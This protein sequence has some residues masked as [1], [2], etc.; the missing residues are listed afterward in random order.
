MQRKQKQHRDLQRRGVREEPL[1]VR[2]AA[3]CSMTVQRPPG[4]LAT[5]QSRKWTWL[6]LLPPPPPP[7][8]PAVGVRAAAAVLRRRRVGHVGISLG[9]R[10]SAENGVERKWSS[11]PSF[12]SSSS[13]LLLSSL[14]SFPRTR[15][16]GRAGKRWAA[17]LTPHPVLCTAPPP[18]RD[19]DMTDPPPP[20]YRRRRNTAAAALHP[21]H[22]AWCYISPHTC[23]CF[24][25]WPSSCRPG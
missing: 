22:H 7:P 2:V 4:L 24:R 25:G 17:P 3:A 15:R 14:M 6:R 21:P 23:Y 11:P 13:S 9:R 18:T 1:A 12:R 16:R 5:G 10:G 19:A 20:Q 8:A